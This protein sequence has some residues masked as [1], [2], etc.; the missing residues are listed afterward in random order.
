M[1]DGMLLKDTWFFSEISEHVLMVVTFDGPGNRPR[2]GA[3]ELFGSLAGRS[4]MPGNLWL[5]WP[6]REARGESLGIKL[7]PESK[8]PPFIGPKGCPSP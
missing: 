7:L 8:P 3:A 5:R 1:C 2:G 4:V 6:G